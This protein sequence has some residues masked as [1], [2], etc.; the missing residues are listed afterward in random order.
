MK[1]Y[2]LVLLLNVS[3]S[4]KDR[5]DFLLSVE[6]QLKSSIIQKD[7]IWLMTTA[8]DLWEKKWNNKFYFVSYYI[9]ADKEIANS[10][11]QFFLYNKMLYRYFLFSMNKKDWMVS[12]EKVQEELQTVLDAWEEKKKWN[13]VTFF[14]Y[15]EN[16]KYI[17]WKSINMLKK[18][19]TRFGNIKPRKYTDNKVSVQKK[20]RNEIIKAREM[21]LLEFIK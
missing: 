3:L 18:Y 2:E 21:W 1:H 9:D 12:F 13:K 6:D 4:E 10:V 15:S 17:N 11:K 8:H 16:A 14:T 20:I 7:D 19:M 5:K